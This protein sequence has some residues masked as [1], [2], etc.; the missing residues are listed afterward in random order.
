MGMDPS[1]AVRHDPECC[2]A[3]TVVHDDAAGD[4]Y[5]E[6]V[7]GPDVFPGTRRRRPKLGTQYDWSGRAPK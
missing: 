3:F 2:T 4:H 6:I 7:F 1:V 5:G